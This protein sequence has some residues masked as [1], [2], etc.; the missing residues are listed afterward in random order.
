VESLQL[1]Y[2]SP[3]TVD[4]DWTVIA[5][6]TAAVWQEG[7]E[8]EQQ[9]AGELGGP[10]PVVAFRSY[11]E[12]RIAAVCD[13]APLRTWGSRSLMYNLIR[14]LAGVAGLSDAR[15]VDL[16]SGSIKSRMIWLTYSLSL[17]TLAAFLGFKWRDTD[18]SGAGSIQWFHERV[19]TGDNS[20]RK[21]ILEYNEDD[22]RAMRV[23]VD[24]VSTLAAQR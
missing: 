5:S 22:C 7:G 20:I 8:D 10:F 1:N 12:G 19:E 16:H 15:S 24:A 13:D 21:R 11:G 9:S 3:M 18:P 2:V 4:S 14:W 6:T 17:K 23:L